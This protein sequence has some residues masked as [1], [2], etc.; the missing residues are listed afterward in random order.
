MISKQELAQL[1]QQEGREDELMV[2]SFERLKSLPEDPAALFYMGL[3][4]S[5]SGNT[6]AAYTLYKMAS[7]FIPD[8]P[9][10]LNNLALSCVALDRVDDAIDLFKRALAKRDD[11]HFYGNLATAHLEKGDYARAVAL[12]NSALRMQDIKNIKATR[13]FAKLY[14]GEWLDAW[15]DYSCAIGGKQRKYVDYGLTDWFPSGGVPRG[16]RIIM[17]G[18]QGIGDEMMYAGLLHRFMQEYA[19][20]EVVLDVDKR[21][22]A[23]FARSFPYATVYGTRR[24]E[25]YWLNRHPDLQYQMPI[26]ELARAL[27]ITP[28]TANLG[29]FLVV[30]P[31]LQR[32]YDA[33]MGNMPMRIGVTWSGG[34]KGNHPEAREMGADVLMALC[35]YL[36]RQG[37]AIYSLQYRETTQAE[38]NEHA[39]PIAHHHFATGLGASYDHTAAFISNL[40]AVIGVDTA[41]HHA[42]AALGVPSFV[43]LNN[44]CTWV[45]NTLVD[46]R[47]PWYQAMRVF[48]QEP[49][50]SWMQTVERFIAS[51][52]LGQL[53]IREAA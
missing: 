17:H 5:R 31:K 44:S 32:M 8:E 29:A 46:G 3:A 22:R 7:Q 26:G 38:I 9:D 19:P 51:E 49:G 43:L 21:L 2:Q 11:P 52:P 48:R 16:A 34:S 39:L 53:T 45:H 6:G 24:D 37:A 42:A 33:L 13:G 47:S 35:R 4:C 18:E 10:L 41:A 1:A 50:E 14:L 25:K 12:C 27:K 15:E 36:T 30:D 20:Q 40:D 28:E 23:L